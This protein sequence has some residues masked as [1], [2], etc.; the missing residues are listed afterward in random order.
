MVDSM[1]TT[2]RAN[3]ERIA[4]T[5]N[6]AIHLGIKMDSGLLVAKRQIL[7]FESIEPYAQSEPAFYLEDGQA[8]A[9]MEALVKYY[10]FNLDTSTA[11]N[12]Y[13]YERG[14]VDTLTAA[15]LDMLRQR[16]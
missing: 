7:E 16:T 1:N 6:I 4:L 9:L 15:I 8:R 12:D 2:Y 10:N 5:N 13:I 3:V 14:R 11:R